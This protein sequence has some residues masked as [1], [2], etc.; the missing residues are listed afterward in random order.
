M[1]YPEKKYTNVFE[2]WHQG[3]VATLNF[4][5][6]TRDKVCVLCKSNNV[7]ITKFECD[8]PIHGTI[9]ITYFC[10]SCERKDSVNYPIVSRKTIKEFDP[11]SNKIDD[12]LKNNLQIDSF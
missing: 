6:E 12:L 9:E 7:T 10:Q 5:I 8:D 3:G 1:Y 11:N 4:K 2:Y